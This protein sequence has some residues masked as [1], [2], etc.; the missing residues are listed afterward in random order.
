MELDTRLSKMGV[1]E[2]ALD[3]NLHLR[4]IDPNDTRRIVA[5]ARLT[6][7][8]IEISRQ[9]KNLYTHN[10]VRGIGQELDKLGGM[11][12]MQGVWYTIQPVVGAS[13]SSEIETCWNGIGNWLR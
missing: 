6:V 1:G 4:G 2:N 3:M 7:E 10:R 8:L 12:A 11:A 13:K 5:I 9:E